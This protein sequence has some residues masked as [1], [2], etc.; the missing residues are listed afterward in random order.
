MDEKEREEFINKFEKGMDNIIGF[1][2]LGGI[3]LK[4]LI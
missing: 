2:V 4:E 3:F 1:C